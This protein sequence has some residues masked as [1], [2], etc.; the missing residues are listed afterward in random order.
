MTTSLPLPLSL[1]SSSTANTFF[2]RCRL[3]RMMMIRDS[4][5]ATLTNMGIVAGLT[6][7]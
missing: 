3:L 6:G 1:N 2:L 4:D 7:D 5:S